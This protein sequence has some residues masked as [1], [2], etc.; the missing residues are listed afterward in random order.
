MGIIMSLLIKPCS[1]NGKV[2]IPPSKSLS[3]RAIICASLSMEG[4]SKIDNI[5][6]SDDIRAT[7][8]G[9]KVLGADIKE[10]DNFI[11]VKRTNIISS[12]IIDCNESGSTLR[13]LIPLSL[14]LTNECTFTGSGRLIDRPLDVYYE[15][16]N[17]FNIEYRTSEGRLPLLIRGNLPNGTYKIPGNVSSQFI[18]GLFF[19]LPLLE[20]DSEISIAGALESKGYIDLTSDIMKRYNI[21]IEK[22]DENNYFIKGRQKYRAQDYS[23]EGDFSQAAFFLAANALGSSI[24]C[25][26]LNYDSLQ[27]DKEILNIIEKYSSEQREV[28]IDASQIPDLIPAVSVIAALKENCITNIVNAGRLRLKESDRLNAIASEMNKLGALIQET[29]D[30]LIIKGR[31]S[32]YGA[33]V[34]SRNDHRIAMAMAIA[35]TRCEAPIV[36]EGFQ[37]VKKSY[38]GFWD[39]YRSLGGTAYELNDRK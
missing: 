28:T 1:L 16:F 12:S 14:V 3:H 30:G 11:L 27:G 38:P 10:K 35:A 26:G 32:L 34:N 23:V 13:F 9:M 5:I 29:E 25:L 20:G 4:E 8:Q 39:D 7:I 2:I 22:I 18:T 33:T 6:F 37:S 21:H 31:K 15:I 24:E 17:K 36:L 19:A